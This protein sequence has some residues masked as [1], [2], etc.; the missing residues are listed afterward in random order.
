MVMSVSGISLSHIFSLCGFQRWW[1]QWAPQTWMTGSEFG[2]NP[3]LGQVILSNYS[4]LIMSAM[5]SQITGV[6]ILCS[7]VCS[8]AVQRNHQ[9]SAS[10]AFMR[11]I[12][13]WLMDSSHKGPVTRKMFPFNAVIM[14]AKYNLERTPNAVTP[15]LS[16]HR[17]YEFH[18]LI[19]RI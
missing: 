16:D 4:D 18:E 13:Q 11:G 8:G 10:L 7:T 1:Y 19:R 5:A 9:S 2:Q 15:S 14:S 17:A 12:H 3:R 6:S